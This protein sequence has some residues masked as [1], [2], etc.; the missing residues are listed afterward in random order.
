MS[1]LKHRC[2]KVPGTSS[3]AFSISSLPKRR[4]S[5]HEM[6]SHCDVVMITA[7][8]VYEDIIGAIA[9]CAHFA[10]RLLDLDG[11]NKSAAGGSSSGDNECDA[12]GGESASLS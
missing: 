2:R 11:N 4:N 12:S 7:C 5:L 1:S 10:C 9:D 3:C 6:R 8:Q